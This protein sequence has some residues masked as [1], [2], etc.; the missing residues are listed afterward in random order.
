VRCIFKRQLKEPL[1]HWPLDWRGGAVGKPSLY[2][3][4]YGYSTVP[5]LLSMYTKGMWTV[6]RR[7]REVIPRVPRGEEKMANLVQVLHGTVRE[8]VSERKQV[9]VQSQ[10]TSRDGCSHALFQARVFHQQRHRTSVVPV[11]WS[12]C[13]NIKHESIVYSCDYDHGFSSS[14]FDLD[15][16]FHVNR[17]NSNAI[18]FIILF[19]NMI[20]IVFYLKIY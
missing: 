6:R 10:E 1:N 11:L 17:C 12:L 19:K 16:V 7:C 20:M 9:S 15:Q 5:W 2:C 14:F 18:I 8:I 4:P 13:K 3:T